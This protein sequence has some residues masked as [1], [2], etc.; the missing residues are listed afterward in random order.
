[1]RKKAQKKKLFLVKLIKKNWEAFD[2]MLQLEVVSA[3][4]LKFSVWHVYVTND[5]N[6]YYYFELKFDCANSNP[7]LISY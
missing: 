5:N 7:A 3:L 4:N 1:M 2:S 6:Y